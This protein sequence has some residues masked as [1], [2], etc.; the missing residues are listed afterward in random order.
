MKIIEDNDLLLL[1]DKEC[2]LLFYF[3]AKWCGPCQKIKPLI[4]KLSEGADSSKLE[5]YLIDIDENDKIA[6]EFK[7]RSV[8]TFYLY[9]K[10]ELKGQTGGA[11]IK[12]VKELLKENM[13]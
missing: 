2:Y 13:K 12:K 8:P 5:I 6:D 11:D 1:K 4:E 7:I 10:K 9:H 3:T